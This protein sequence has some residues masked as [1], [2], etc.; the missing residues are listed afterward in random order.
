MASYQVGDT[1]TGVVTGIEDY[2]IF[3]SFG[4]NCSGL[5]HISEISDSFVKSVSD[6]ANVN[7]SL[8]AKIISVEED[9]HYKLSLKELDSS[10]KGEN[11][12][13]VETEKGFETLK[14]KLPEW[15]EEAYNEIE[16]K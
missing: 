15:V 8:T 9:G 7:D 1:I 13:I 12:S 14:N 16:K 6:Y 2:G 11:H 10:K 5:I 3:L 4:E